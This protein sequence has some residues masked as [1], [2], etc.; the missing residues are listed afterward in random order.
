MTELYDFIKKLEGKV[1]D[2]KRHIEACLGSPFYIAENY[3]RTLH[4]GGLYDALNLAKSY[5]IECD[6]ELK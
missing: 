1:D 4:L 5:M 6:K 3:Q 2:E